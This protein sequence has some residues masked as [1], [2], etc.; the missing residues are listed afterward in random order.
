MV[1][2]VIIA[3]HGKSL[4]ASGLTIREDCS[5]IAFKYFLQQMV[6]FAI[7]VELNLGSLRVENV[8]KSEGFELF[9]VV[10]HV[11]DFLSL[12]VDFKSA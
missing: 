10:E 1:K 3:F 4:A 11:P 2:F 7:L 5:V 9:I 8:V 12:I 6:D